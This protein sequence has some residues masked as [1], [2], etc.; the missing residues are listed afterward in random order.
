MTTVVNIRGR[1]AKECDVYIGRGVNGRHMLNTPIGQRG[2]LGNPHAVDQI[3]RGKSIQL[4]RTDF[5]KRLETDREFLEAVLAL[6]GQTLG[7]F[8]KPEACHG[9][10]I[11]EFLDG[12]GQ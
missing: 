12:P 2:W 11:A 6:K 7:C 1:H 10:V 5:Y 8:C 9:D 4:F 3:G